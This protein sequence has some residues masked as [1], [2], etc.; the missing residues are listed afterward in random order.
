MIVTWF[1]VIA[2]Y[3]GDFAS[4]QNKISC[5]GLVK[6]N[7][8]EATIRAVCNIGEAEA[9]IARKGRADCVER[10]AK[11]TVSEAVLTGYLRIVV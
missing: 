5:F 1:L 6:I 11:T 7:Q 9:A 4:R 2:N 10:I 8:P 3:V